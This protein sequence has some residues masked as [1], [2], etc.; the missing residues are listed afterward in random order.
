MEDNWFEDFVQD[1]KPIRLWVN[2]ENSF[3]YDLEAYLDKANS[4]LSKR[5]EHI[6]V[7]WKDPGK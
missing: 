5:K 1:P 2:K 6:K 3:A 4:A 7:A